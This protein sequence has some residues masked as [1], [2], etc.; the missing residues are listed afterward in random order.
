MKTPPRFLA[1]R[2]VN[3]V[4]APRQSY[5]TCASSDVGIWQ[6]NAHARRRIAAA[7][8]QASHN[9]PRRQR[10]LRCRLRSTFLIHTAKYDSAGQLLPAILSS[11]PGGSASAST[12][13]PDRRQTGAQG[14]KVC[15]RDLSRFTD[16]HQQRLRRKRG[17]IQVCLPLPNRSGPMTR[18][19]RPLRPT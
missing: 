15:G 1:L 17:A 6:T 16:Y 14:I 10:R 2:H 3:S 5:R 11:R 9:S 19:S 7:S 4:F 13:M 18:Y 12:V 8:R